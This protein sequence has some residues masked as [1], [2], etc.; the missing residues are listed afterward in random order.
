MEMNDIA[1]L[2]LLDLA[3]AMSEG[4]REVMDAATEW[5]LERRSDILARFSAKILVLGGMACRV[6]SM[7]PDSWWFR[8]RISLLE[9]RNPIKVIVTKQCLRKVLSAASEL[10]ISEN[11]L[12]ATMLIYLSRLSDEYRE[13]SGDPE[14]KRKA[15]QHYR[16]VIEEVVWL[17]SKEHPGVLQSKITAAADKFLSAAGMEVQRESTSLSNIFLIDVSN[18]TEENNET[19]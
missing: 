10:G 4:R 2:N 9:W 8:F 3:K 7:M 18:P 1:G 6:E 13:K 15:E 14:V 5:A 16:A 17:W 12:K 19:K 11:Q